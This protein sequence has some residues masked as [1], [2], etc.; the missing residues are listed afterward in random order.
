M[1]ADAPKVRERGTRLLV[2]VV[3][4]FEIRSLLLQHGSEDFAA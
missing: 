1:R 3:V 4:E 2:D